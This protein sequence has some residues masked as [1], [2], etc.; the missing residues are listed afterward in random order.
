MFKIKVAKVIL[1]QHS[2]LLKIDKKAIK[3][4]LFLV[5]NFFCLFIVPYLPIY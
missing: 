4:L 2:F 3:K 1:V 5:F